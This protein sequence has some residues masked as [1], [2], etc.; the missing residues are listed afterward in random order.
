MTECTNATDTGK[1]WYN[2]K[3]TWLPSPFTRDAMLAAHS[4]TKIVD[5]GIGYLSGSKEA[6]NE[7][8]DFS[9]ERVADDSSLHTIQF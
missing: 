5:L 4:D 7:V 2:E 9:V 1:V 8:L 3:Q 6:V